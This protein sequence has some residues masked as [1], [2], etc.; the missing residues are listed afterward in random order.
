M[1][2]FFGFFSEEF[3]LDVTCSLLKYIMDKFSNLEVNAKN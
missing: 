1:S 2:D 3:G